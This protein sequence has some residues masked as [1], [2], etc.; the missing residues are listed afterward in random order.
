MTTLKV[1]FNSFHFFA[2]KTLFGKSLHSR[3]MENRPFWLSNGDCA[4]NQFKKWHFFS[5]GLFWLKNMK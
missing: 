1:E 4:P 3:F 5:K 2:T